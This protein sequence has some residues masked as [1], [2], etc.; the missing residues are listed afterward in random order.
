MPF[1][2]DGGGGTPS[3][4]PTPVPAPIATSQVDVYVDNTSTGVATRTG[5]IAAPFL[6]I[7]EALNK[8]GKP[9]S[10]A[11]SLRLMCV[12]VSSGNYTETL[13]VPEGRMIK[14]VCHGWVNFTGN[15]NYLS[16]G[17]ARLGSGIRSFLSI[18]G[19]DNNLAVSTHIAR[20]GG[21]LINGRIVR[22]G[23]SVTGI[24][25]HDL[26]LSN[27]QVTGGIGWDASIAQPGGTSA[28]LVRSRLQGTT[29]DQLN[30]DSTGFPLVFQQVEDSKIE[31]TLKLSRFGGAVRTEF[32]SVAMTLLQ[33]G[34]DIPPYGFFDCVWTGTNSI[35]APANSL[36]LNGVSFVNSAAV[37]L[38]GGVTRQRIEDFTPLATG[39]TDNAVTRF[40]GTTGL[41]Q[42]SGVTIDDTNNVKGAASVQL[43]GGTGTGGTVRWNDG[44]GTIEF[45]T[46][47]T[48]NDVTSGTTRL[49]VA[50]TGTTVTGNL[51]YTGTKS[52]W[53]GEVYMVGNAT[54]TT[55]TNTAK[56]FKVAGT[57]I[58]GNNKGFDNG[59]VSNCLRYTGAITRM[60]H[61]AVSFSFSTAS[62]SQNVEFAV[63]KNGVRIDSSVQETKT[64]TAGDVQSTALHVVATLDIY[65]CL[66]VFC[67][68][69]STASN[70][71]VKNLN[72][73]AMNAN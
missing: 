22:K 48:Y 58:I 44:D 36:K 7:Q 70:V 51:R 18:S 63:F 25:T 64:G 34:G 66:E 17:N 2:I 31:G 50:S 56:Y 39:A 67:R 72:F 27:V 33:A 28:Y 69:L 23:T 4:T 30:D 5:N 40:D 29:S 14:I 10:S 24:T 47:G 53:M 46:G 21:M 62:N 13:N 26:Y 55:I 20:Q 52:H 32:S 8:I 73:F 60:F 1:I 9:T 19:G 6:T 49:S 38:S 45:K 16:D 54:A 3:P 35:T 42:T 57:T 71:T 15:I 37:T 11:D 59:G 43:T 65:D 61:V 12:H 68:N 41:L